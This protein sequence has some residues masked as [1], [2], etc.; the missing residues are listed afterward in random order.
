MVALEHSRVLAIFCCTI[1]TSDHRRIESKQW[2]LNTW[3]VWNENCATRN[4]EYSRVLE[5]HHYWKRCEGIQASY[6]RRP[7]PQKRCF[8]CDF[9]NKSFS[10]IQSNTGLEV[11]KFI[12]L[13]LHV[14]NI[15]IICV[16][17]FCDRSYNIF[18][19]DGQLSQWLYNIYKQSF[20][21]QGLQRKTR[22]GLKMCFLSWTLN[23]LLSAHHGEQ[24][25]FENIS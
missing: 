6:N 1:F 10:D 14:Y 17:H 21:I 15:I 18:S 3:V 2:T 7:S 23:V 4:R 8:C 22:S 16:M 12:L 20:H 24:V 13:S 5:C 11:T 25:A 19:L 9:V